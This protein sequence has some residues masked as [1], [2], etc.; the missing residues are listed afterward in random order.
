MTEKKFT[1]RDLP[2]ND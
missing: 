1:S 2:A